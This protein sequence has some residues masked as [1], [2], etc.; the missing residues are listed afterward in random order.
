M[1]IPYSLSPGSTSVDD[2]RI[3][4]LVTSAA[5]IIALA[6]TGRCRFTTSRSTQEACIRQRARDQANRTNGIIVAGDRVVDR[7]RIAVRIGDR[8]QRHLELARLG[9]R[10]GLLRGVDD[11]DGLRQRAHAL[12]AANVLLEP[13]A[14]LLELGNLLLGD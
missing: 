5:R 13:R 7:A 10:D 4:P 1:T 9:D 14:L 6:A 3:L 11:E 8:D 12:D 2:S